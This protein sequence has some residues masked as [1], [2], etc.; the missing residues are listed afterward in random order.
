MLDLSTVCAAKEQYV[1][2]RQTSFD[3]ACSP[4]AVMSCDARRRSTVCAVQGRCTSDVVRPCV[5]SKGGD[6][7]PRLKLST[8]CDIQ[9]R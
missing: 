4:R 6:G 3:R 1:M 7:M 9:R 5:L 8:L 2:P